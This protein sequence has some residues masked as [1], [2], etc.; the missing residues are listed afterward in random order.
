MTH[1]IIFEFYSLLKLTYLICVLS[2][3]FFTFNAQNISRV[4][5]EVKNHSMISCIF[6]DIESFDCVC[7]Q[8]KYIQMND[9]EF[10]VLASLLVMHHHLRFR[11]MLLAFSV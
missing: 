2:C 3:F 9:I 1:L 8:T 11:P 10:K 7:V 5:C 4:H 6:N